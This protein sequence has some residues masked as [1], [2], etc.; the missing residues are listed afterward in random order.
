MSKVFYNIFGFT[1]VCFGLLNISLLMDSMHEL[2]IGGIIK[3]TTIIVVCIG[4]GI[5]IMKRGEKAKPDK[6]IEK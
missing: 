5:F 3:N 6:R 2:D 1:L 4:F